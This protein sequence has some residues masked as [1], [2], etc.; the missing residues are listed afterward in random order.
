VDHKVE[1]NDAVRINVLFNV[2]GSGTAKSRR[3]ED[4]AAFC[5]SEYRA[6]GLTDRD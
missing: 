5:F 4:A 2:K 1:L 6:G 3:I